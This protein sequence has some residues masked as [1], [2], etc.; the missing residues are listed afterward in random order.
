MH[1]K[2]GLQGTGSR[3]LKYF[4]ALWPTYFIDF[5]M[6]A[7]KQPTRKQSERATPKL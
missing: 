6:T 3:S 7:L 4:L 1:R 5:L 2:M